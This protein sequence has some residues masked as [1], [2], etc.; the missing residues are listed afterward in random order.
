VEQ[1]EWQPFGR[2]LRWYREAAGLSQSELAE[3]ANVTANAIGMLE[4]GE[5]RRPQPYTLRQLA[6]ALNLSP[7]EHERLLA[8]ASTAPTLR[9]PVDE[10]S[11]HLQRPADLA[12]TISAL[13]A[14]VTRFIGRRRE[15]AEVRRLLAS[16]RLVT[17]TG[18]GGTGKTRLAIEVARISR[19]AFPGGIR[20][21]NL[22]PIDDPALAVLAIERGLGAEQVP[23]GSS[24]ERLVGQIGDQHLLLV[25]DNFE[26]VLEAAPVIGPLLV[27]LPNLHV[28]A[29]S[30]VV[31]HLYGEH[32]YRVPPLELAGTRDPE[33]VEQVDAIQLFVESARLARHDFPTDGP[34]LAVVAQICAQLDGLPLAIELA[35]ARTRFFSPEELLDRLT[36]RLEPLT[37]GGRD[38]PERQQTLRRAFDWSYDLLTP[39]LRALFIRL[40]VFGGSV[41]PADVAAVAS[42]RWTV[43]EVLDGLKT[44]FECGLLERVVDQ[45]GTLRFALLQTVRAYACERLAETG[46]LAGLQRRH[47]ERYL[48]LA[49]DAAPSLTGPEQ[50]HWLSRLDLE[51]DNFWVALQWAFERSEGTTLLRFAA[52][53]WRYW[54]LSWHLDEGRNWLERALAAVEPEAREAVEPRL[55]ALFG[56]ARI[57]F[58]QGDGQT[59][60]ARLLEGLDLARG[61]ASPY[62]ISSMLSQLGLLAYGRGD[63]AEARSDQEE[64]LALRRELGNPWHIATSLLLLGRVAFVVGD[65]EVARR[66]YEEVV[67]LMHQ[68]G[69]SLELSTALPELGRVYVEMG[70]SEEARACYDEC[71]ALYQHRSTSEFRPHAVARL[72]ALAWLLGEYEPALNY[73]QAA[74]ERFRDAG[75][76][77]WMAVCL[78]GISVALVALG[79]PRS[80]V[81]LRAAV[82]AVRRAGGGATVPLDPPLP[83]H[84]LETART[85]L[86]DALFAGSWAAGQA[87]TPEQAVDEA[88]H[89]SSSAPKS[90]P[91]HLA[92]NK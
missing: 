73:Y 82:E 13:P 63:Y 59:A 52:A 74:L 35:A 32:E 48:A 76:A 36:N 67:V 41:S 80:A 70:E 78:E 12:G 38:L 34:T 42:P 22:A 16:S 57:A 39:E 3:R 72:G 20:F 46:E 5:R 6:R 81:R 4:R 65:Y 43:E 40:G 71:V 2:L 15:I 90:A 79:R 33:R 1:Q 10:P 25:L 85:E 60:R 37:G 84:A 77:Q 45:H 9:H 17:L 26:Q 30:R 49:E 92:A 83:E 7:A 53:L 31:L 24:L 62:W 75:N 88:L 91:V 87:L 50:A 28:L 55:H 69:E 66:S 51:H 47:A 64:A 21:V 27:R 68:I 14:P 18:V 89:E 8:S 86:G 56:L 19:D 54:D 58:N 61:A 44:L 11:E 23:G 29:T